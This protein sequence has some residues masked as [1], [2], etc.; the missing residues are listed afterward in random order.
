MSGVS[1]NHIADHESDHST[2]PVK[3]PWGVFRERQA[4]PENIHIKTNIK[5]GEFIM[6]TLFAQ[7][8]ILAERKINHVL[9]DPN[10]DK[11]LSKLLQRGEDAVFDQLMNTL[12]FVAENSLPSLL[13]A[14]FGWY[15]RQ[16]PMDEAGN[17]LYRR[18]NK[19]K[20]EKEY[21]CEK[22][23][24]AVDFVYCL[25][26]IEILKQ[27]PYH[28]GHDE[29]IN[30]IISLAFRHFKYR[31]GTQMS[32]NA[33]NINIVADLFAEVVGVLAQSRFPAVKKRFLF[34]LKELRSK[35]Q[36]RTTVHSIISLLMGLKFFRVKMHPIEDFQ[37]CIQFL[38]ECGNYFLEVKEKEKE[39][40][41]ALAGLFVEILLP[42]AAV[43]KNEVNVPVL[44][45]FVET[46]YTPTLDLAMKKRHSLAL[47]PLVTC[48]LCVSQKQFFLNN[49]SNFLTQC[50]SKLK[51]R[52]PTTARVALES[53]YRLLW[54]YMIRIKCESNTITNSRLQS[55]VG[56]LFP[57]GS[58]FIMPKDAP[59]NI[60]VKI[61]Q[62]IAQERLDFAMKEIIFDLLG[63]GKNSKT[64]YAP[65]R[66]CIGL[67]AFLVIADGLQ[68]KEVEPPMP[69]TMGM[70]PSGS[71]LRSKKTF[72][73]KFLTDQTAK[74]IGLQNYYSHVRKS[75]DSI[76]RFLDSQVG[77]PMLLIR[78]E[79]LNRETDNL[80]S[81]ER[82][83]KIDLFRTCVVALPRIMPDGMMVGG[84]IDLLSRLTVHM[85]DELG[86]LAFQ[87]LQNI[88]L[89]LS[90]WRHE[91]VNGFTHFIQREVTDSFPQLLEQSVRRLISLLTQWKAAVQ[92]S[93]SSKV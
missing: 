9:E 63:V 17:C 51:D 6:Q 53:L 83:P 28:P 42:V 62:F 90:E 11:P 30:H 56:S 22:R 82:K 85:D 2:L 38:Q 65:E 7:F 93:S 81:G 49:W 19:C 92:G 13:Q 61:V 23:D 80:L 91:V 39:I 68:Q 47:F 70:L 24:L 29:Q 59:L 74:N 69:Q 12:Y 60:F 78:S 31:E 16:N 87:S 64:Y 73:N 50:L 32:R 66:M 35:E 46:L 57:K 48:L 25:V 14:L 79:N 33:Q 27:L 76:L 10:Q 45:H 86:K 72:I 77:K 41:H 4:F 40:K 52:D 84:L 55:I 15:D 75:F 67:R 26:L 88:S 1:G 54:V 20:G 8:T 21:L 5:P 44:K 3:L 89:D 36:T 34:E 71:T 18:G 37:A 58:R 43:V